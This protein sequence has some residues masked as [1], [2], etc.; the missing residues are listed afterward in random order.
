VL[1][2]YALGLALTGYACILIAARMN[3][4]VRRE[5][6]W[7]VVL[8]LILGVGGTFALIIGAALFIV[9]LWLAID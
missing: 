9:A 5:D 3:G 1:K 6:H 7:L 2:W 4:L 8:E